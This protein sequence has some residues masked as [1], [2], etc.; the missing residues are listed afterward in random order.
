MNY[1]INISTLISLSTTILVIVQCIIVLLLLIRQVYNLFLIGYN[2]RIQKENEENNKYLKENI[3]K[4][5]EKN[6]KGELKDKSFKINKF[7]L[8]VPAHNEEKV[9]ENIIE[10]LNKIEYDKKLYEICI[11]AHNCKDKTAEKEKKYIK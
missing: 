9:I 6:K 5:Y 10:S 3:D 4:Y 7:I 8:A 1:T 11:I 2:T